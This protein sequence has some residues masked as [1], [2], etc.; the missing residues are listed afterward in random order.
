MIQL[1]KLR[2]EIGDLFQSNADAYAHCVGRDYRMGAGIAVQF[3]K[4]YGGQAELRAQNIPVGGVA[5]LERLDQPTKVYYMVTK[6]LSARSV[7]TR[8]D[9]VS[10]LQRLK[11]LCEQHGVKQLAIPKIGCGLDKLPINFVLEQ[12]ESTFSDSPV[13]ITMYLLPDDQLVEHYD[14]YSRT[15][16]L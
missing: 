2:I 12:I 3:R 13:Q 7:P 11:V 9:F 16:V 4:I 15:V 6:E 1:N 5:F 14:E 8:K 10:S